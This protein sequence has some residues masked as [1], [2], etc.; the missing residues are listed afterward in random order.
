MRFTN[1][2]IVYHRANTEAKGII[3]GVVTRSHGYTYFV[4]WEDRA[5]G[6]HQACELTNEKPPIAVS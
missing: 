6:E 3:T 5:E 2:E 4:V 1:G